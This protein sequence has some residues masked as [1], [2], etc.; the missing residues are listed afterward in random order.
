MTQES[1]HKIY[2]L[3][4]THALPR[5]RY[6]NDLMNILSNI[7]DVYQ[8]KA[9][10]EDYRYKVL[11]DEIEKHYVMND[12][13]ADDKLFVG[14]LKI[15]DDEAKFINF[16]EQITNMLRTDEGFE[17]YKEDLSTVLKEESLQLNEEQGEYKVRP[18]GALYEV[19]KGA[20]TFYVC[21][22]DVT[23]AVKFYE[24]DV[25]WP[26]DENCFVLTFDYLWNDYSYYTRYRLYFV[27]NGE[28]TDVGEVKI[29]KRGTSNTSEHLPKQFVA[30]D[31]DY[32][33]LG[34]T[35]YYYRR[36]RSLF[37]SDAHIVLS[38]L[39]D[40]A[41]YEAIYKEFENDGEYR[42][43]LLRDNDSD[44]AR[45]EGRYCV[46]GRDLND[47]YAFK[48]NY[49]LPY[50]GDDVEIDF[51]YKYSGQDYER[52][53][54]IIGENGVGKTSLIKQILHSLVTNDNRSFTTPRP[55]FSSVL[56]ISYSPFDLY[57][58]NTQGKAPF[59]NYEYSGLMK[60]KELMFSVEDQVNTLIENIKAIYRRRYSFAKR[61]GDLINKVIPIESVTELISEGDGNDVD[62]NKEGLLELCMNASSG[63]TMYLYS[64]S[65]IMAKIRSDSLIIMDEPEQHLHPRAITALMHSLYN[66]LERYESY[67]LIS[68]HSPYVIRELVSPNVMIFKRHG[69][70][71]SVNRIGI[72]SFGEDVSVL[73][74]IVF[75]NM[76]EHKRYEDFI[77][78]VV[79]KNDYNYEASVRELLEC[80]VACENDY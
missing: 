20:L 77:Q 76:G 7:W 4:K 44:R 70:E 25:K 40:T 38:Q 29:M 55:L 10:G 2:E 51:N 59:I 31:Q 65:A 41:F 79:E 68:T 30:L 37:G 35:P 74:D 23:N 1:Q 49:K 61:W 64:I 13:W 75:G 72:E 14:I 50:P 67:G 39:R 6:D 17:K 52:I 45:R 57:R 78:E 42:S 48:F 56:M 60:D 12:D 18:Q 62:V 66:I 21:D 34:M 24:K 53:V 11:G 32:C 43:S 19:P 22:S 33:S 73:S 8:Q 58:I 47:A 26:V 63:E 15:F 71:L 69:N 54:G 5:L 3:L 27:K 36:M 28:P 80:Q 46:Y 9:T 16:T